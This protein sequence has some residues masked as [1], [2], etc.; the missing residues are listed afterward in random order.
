MLNGSARRRLRGTLRWLCSAGGRDRSLGT[1]GVPYQD[2][3]GCAPNLSERG[4]DHARDVPRAQRMM[5]G[6]VLR[7]ETTISKARRF[8]VRQR[9]VW[10]GVHRWRWISMRHAVADLARPVQIRRA[11]QAA[12]VAAGKGLSK[13]Q[14]V[15]PVQCEEHTLTAPAT[16]DRSSTTKRVAGIEPA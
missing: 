10:Q 6:S 8:K 2:F 12:K 16:L 7:V 13:Q 14:D 15:A 11:A 9:T 5:Q 3:G 1:M 4:K